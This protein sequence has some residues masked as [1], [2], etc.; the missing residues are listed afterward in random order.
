MTKWREQELDLLRR[1]QYELAQREATLQLENW[2]QEH[3]QAIRQDAIQRS[4]A[5]TV[6]KITEHLVPYLPGFNYNPKDARFIGSP[7]DLIIFDGLNDGEVRKVVFVE[8]KTG[9]SNLSSRERRLRDAVKAGRIEWI[10][11]RPSADANL[12]AVGQ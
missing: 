9:T 7:I 11:Y 5:V 10:E 1:Q 6:G 2:K 3:E 4:Q 8:V 12:I